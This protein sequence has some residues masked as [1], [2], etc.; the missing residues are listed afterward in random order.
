[1]DAETIYCYIRQNG[2]N[3]TLS[4]RELNY[5]EPYSLTNLFYEIAESTD[6]K[7]LL[8]RLSYLIKG[9]TEL[10]KRAGRKLSYRIFSEESGNIILKIRLKQE[11]ANGLF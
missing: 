5:R 9:R 6:E 3:R 2:S 4:I 1:M 11:A 8:H 10:Q 7:D